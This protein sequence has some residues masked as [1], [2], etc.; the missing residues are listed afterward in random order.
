LKR[1]PA[2]FAVL[3][4]HAGV[5]RYDLFSTE[6]MRSP[7]WQQ[8]VARVWDWPEAPP[9]I[10]RHAEALR[11]ANADGV[12]R[13]YPRSPALIAGE[14]RESD[15]LNACE[16]RP[17]D[18]AGLRRELRGGANVHVHARDGWEALTALL[19]PSRARGLVLIDPP[20]ETPGELEHTAEAIGA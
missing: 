3:D 7:E 12:L 2:P 6:A 9:L 10:A 15:V 4:T 19:P 14:L 20:Y 18:Y 8:G 11:R 5:G 13:F 17:E 16:Q 1:K